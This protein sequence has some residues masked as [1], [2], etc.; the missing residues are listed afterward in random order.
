MQ[1]QFVVKNKRRLA[2]KLKV[3]LQLQKGDLFLHDYALS[4][5]SEENLRNLSSSLRST[6]ELLTV[7]DSD[8]VFISLNY[9]IEEY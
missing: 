8:F 1:E 6:N 5:P 3:I 2:K 7:Y 9:L 4:F